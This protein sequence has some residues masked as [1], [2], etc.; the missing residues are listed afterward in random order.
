MG[1][2]TAMHFI[3]RATV[4]RDN[5]NFPAITN[6]TPA[7]GDVVLGLNDNIEYVYD[8][9]SWLVLGAESSYKVIQTA[10]SDPEPSGY[11]STFISS[12]S[13]NPD[14]VISVDKK[15]LPEIL[16]SGDASGTGT[17]S[18]DAT[19]VTISVSSVKA[20]LLKPY[21]AANTTVATGHDN[22]GVNSNNSERV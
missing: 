2:S 16:L 12:I 21:S 4:V 5:A 22:T 20:T 6:H 18:N 7:S 15:N 14:G 9:T 3:G 19:D 1:L 8:G 11:S 10:V 17:V 13:Q